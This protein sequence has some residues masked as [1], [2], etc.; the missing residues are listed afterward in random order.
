MTFVNGL[1]L[2]GSAAIV[3]PIVLHLIM[4]RRP[5]LLEF[6][7]L[8]FLQQRHDTNQRRLRLRHLLLLLL[9]AGAIALLAFALAR[10]KV[11]FS[12]PLSNLGSQEAPVAAALVFDVAPH[13]LCR[14]DN[15][16]R[17]EAAREMGLRLLDQLPRESKIA[18]LDTGMIRHNFDADMG[19]SKQRIERLE[20]VPNSK[21]LAGAVGEAARVL[22]EEKE[23]AR[24][25]VYVFTDLSRAA[26]PA[27]EA[28][29]LQNDLM[30]LSGAAVYVIDLGAT[31]PA[32]FTLDPLKLSNEVLSRGGSVEIQAEVSC[33]GPGGQRMIELYVQ[34]TFDAGGKPQKRGEKMVALGPSGATAVQFRLADLGSGTHQ[35]FVKIVGQ[36]ALAA[37][38]VR[39]FTVEAAP[40]WPVLVVAPRPAQEHAQN[41]VGAIAPAEFRLRGQA[42]FECQVIDFEELGSPNDKSTWQP[43]EK[44]AAVCLLDPPGLEPGTWKKLADYVSEGHRLA[45]FL[46]RRAD[47]ESLNSPVAQQ[48]LPGKLTIWSRNSTYLSPQD[49]QHPILKTFAPW[50]SGT[51]WFA[52]PVLLSWNLG[53]R[54]EGTAVVIPYADGRPALLERPLGAGRVLTMTTPISDPGYGKPW[55]M[56]PFSFKSKPW[57]FVVL[58]NELTSYLVGAEQQQL[59][60]QAGSSVELPLDEQD[61]KRLFVVTKPDGVTGTL[62]PK[63]K[64]LHIGAEE[65]SEVGSY[66]VQAGGTP[67]V[68]RGFSVNLGP[69]QTRLDRIEEG[70]L[71]EFFG[72]FKPNVAKNLEQID[73]GAAVG[74]VARDLYPA[75]ILALALVLAAEYFAANRFYREA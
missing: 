10:P 52:F 72:P 32:N 19:V 64:R 34:D 4:R 51:P 60:Y 57:P 24:K 40:A 59:N 71:V 53:D 43:L 25:E 74:R 66:R 47:K 46:G 65:A 67:R 63:G 20:V 23:L 33:V 45:I 62:E 9:R 8:R 13:M 14:Q 73:R 54:P 5:K 58:M 50:A 22:A 29:S 7:A 75:A 12:G 42:R 49:Y 27:D 17:L 21:P 15:K 1:L 26:W 35:G 38:D 48:L 36:D 16:T 18:V 39:H 28:A 11:K 37:D 68:D 69:N 30:A 41:L 56:L 31:D 70:Q 44:Y 6:P 2:L 55:N 61:T 3:I